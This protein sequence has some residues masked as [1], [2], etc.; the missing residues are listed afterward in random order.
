MRKLVLESPVDAEITI[1]GRRYLYFGGT[2]YL[3]MSGRHEIAAAAKQAIDS[4]GLSSSAS[5]TSTGTNRLHLEVE[6]ALSTFADT[7]DTVIVSSGFLAMQSLL[8]GVVKEDDLLFLQK[9]AHPS[10]RQAVRLTGLD[11]QEFDIGRLEQIRSVSKTVRRVLVIAEG[12]APLTGEVLPLPG[13]V[14]LFRNHDFRILIDDAH[15]LGVVGA[16]GRGTAEFHQCQSGNILVCATLS[17][18][19]GAFGGCVL[20]G[21]ELGERIRERSLAYICG[22]PPS[23]PDLGAALAAIQLVTNQPELIHRLHNNVSIL[24]EGL[25]RLGLPVGDTHVP[26]VPLALDRAQRM[27]DLSAELFSQGIVAPFL[28]YP[29][30]PKD[31]L[32]RLVVTASHKREQIEL[33][34]S[35]LEKL[36]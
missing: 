12:I 14:D 2:N 29:G 3:G 34:L 13:L 28:N 33:L 16:T 8:E 31:G 19:F 17:K 4:Y 23:A 5:R 21:K 32:I 35:C 18:A 24:K 9:S 22:S 30:S 6:S 25:K 1:E 27:V 15:G 20:S 11:F 26:I 7:E 36:L 10:I